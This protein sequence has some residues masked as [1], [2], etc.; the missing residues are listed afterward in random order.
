MS[1]QNIKG[2]DKTLEL[3][4]EYIKKDNLQGG[5]L[6]TGPEGVGKKIT[7]KETAKVINCMEVAFDAC[8]TCI[9]C[10]KINKG[11]HPDV[12]IFEEEDS[13]I[14][15]EY[16]RQ[17]KKEMWL[18]PYEAKKKVFIID[19]SH[20]LNYSSSSALLKI[21]EEPSSD[22]LIILVSS[23]PSL[24]F[25]TIVSRCKTLKFSA[26]K[27]AELEGILKNDYQLDD[28]RA[29]FL[30][31]FSEGRLGFALRLKEANIFKKRDETIDKFCFFSGRRPQDLFAEN[32]EEAAVSLNILV[33]WFRDIYMI[34]AGL[35]QQELINLDRAQDLLKTMNRFSYLQLNEILN[36][37]SSSALYL[38]QNINL[39][40]LFSNL[41]KTLSL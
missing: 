34:K 22:T 27:R 4:K 32:K 39:K 28:A 40:L 38:E 31:Y 17:L 23:K 33:S 19:N 8:D 1:F 25:R 3:L 21:L 36:T 10:K 13:E 14:K 29:H 20:R 18:K 35:P 12:H 41:W 16:I 9:S 15:I 5:Y 11:T 24:L 30:A 6:F 37:V 2:Q 26:F 7:A